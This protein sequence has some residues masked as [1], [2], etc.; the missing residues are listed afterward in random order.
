L[1]LALEIGAGILLIGVEKEVVD[2]AV[3]VVMALRVLLGN[4]LGVALIKAGS[5]PKAPNWSLSARERR[6]SVCLTS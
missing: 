3:D 2:A 1:A 5:P 6:P 4:G